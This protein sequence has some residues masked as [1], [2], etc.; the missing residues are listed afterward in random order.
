VA[1]ADH[2]HGIGAVEVLD[3]LFE[4]DAE[5]LNGI[6]IVHVDG[7]IEIHAADGLHQRGKALQI[8][9][10]RV[11]HRNTQLLRHGVGQKLRAALIIGVVDF[12]GL[13]VNDGLGVPG[14]AD[15]VNVAV[16]RVYRH[17]DVGVATAVVIVKAGKE[18][19]VEPA[20]ALQVGTK[21]LLGRLFLRGLLGIRVRCC[22][23]GGQ[24][25]RLLLRGFQ[26]KD[27]H[28]HA[29]GEQDQDDGQ[30]NLQGVGLLSLTAADS[31]GHMK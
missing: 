26:E 11:I 3:A 14:D 8:D 12:A 23:L 21:G 18:D 17:K 20:L 28:Q 2:P 10:D 6:V 1:E 5:V 24:L 31:S 25:R 13:A 4:M 30:E 29:D 7:H 16:H 19:C 22:G 27:L 15:A 9:A